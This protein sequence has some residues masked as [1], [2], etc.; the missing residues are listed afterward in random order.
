MIDAA[1]QHG[2]QKLVFLGS[3]CIYPQLA[4]QPI[5]E[6]Y[7]LTGPLEPTN[8]S[9]AIAKIAGIKLAQAYRQQYG[10]RG[11]QP[12]ADQSVRAGRQFR[13]GDIARAAGA[14]PPLPRGQAIEMRLR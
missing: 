12:D 14:D 5:K 13:S 4:P 8:E 2:A 7:L 3:S 9:Y 11:H 6:E 10:F 1:W